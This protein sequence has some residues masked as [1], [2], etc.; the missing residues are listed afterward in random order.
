MHKNCPNTQL[1]DLT[2]PLDYPA[3]VTCLVCGEP[4]RCERLFLSVWVHID[5]FTDPDG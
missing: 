5:R 2:S 4:I 3:E 1:A